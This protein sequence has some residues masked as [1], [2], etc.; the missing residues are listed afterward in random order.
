VAPV[1]DWCALWRALSEAQA[2]TRRVDPLAD[3]A[4]P[5]SGRAHAFAAGVARRW[6]A[7]DSS[8]ATV[9][10]WLD[11]HPGSSVLD[12]G[13]GTG[14]WA[15]F[16]SPHAARVT[17]VEPSAGM[18]EVLRE[19]LA[20]SR[21]TNVTVVP[22][23]WPDEAI[24]PHDVTLC[25]HAMYGAADFAGFVR[26]L[27][28]V[29]RRHVFLLLRA[30]DP[31]GVMAEATMHVRG[32]RHDS[33]DFQVGYNALLELGIFPDVVME[34]GLWEPWRH[35]SLE[36]AL[37]EVKRRLGLPGAGGH[38]AF[39]AGLLERRLVPADD[40]Y[41]WPRATRSALAHWDVERYRVRG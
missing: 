13:A 37:A 8:R 28:R 29:T 27:E 32:H 39:L 2:R 7:P 25:A 26:G 30:L 40:A 3:P 5:W 1:T 9:A 31:D 23:P 33:P 18:V 11:A 12:I 36:E 34:E 22:R 14:A 16:L 19:T 24:A 6:S 15:A 35:A 10:A 4:D 21:V 38:D 20:G 41:V 17:A